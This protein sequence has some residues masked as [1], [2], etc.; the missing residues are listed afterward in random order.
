MKKL[1]IFTFLIFAFS[2]A[3][4]EIEESLDNVNTQIETDTA[5][6]NNSNNTSK[7]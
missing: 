6:D 2:C 7:I 1:F 5:L 4:N 3:T